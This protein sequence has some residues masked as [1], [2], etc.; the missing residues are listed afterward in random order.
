M[1]LI[2]KIR[3]KAAW[4]IFGAIALAL[5]AFIV[6]DAFMR[7]GSFFGSGST[8]GKVNGESIEHEDFQKKV[9]FYDQ[10]N[11]GQIERNQLTANV[12]DYLV[13]QTI[14]QQQVAKLGLALTP[15][16]RSDVLFGDNPPQWMQQAFTDPKT[17]LFDAATAKKQLQQ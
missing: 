2:Q 5:L 17:G 4:I 1:S 11:G 3:D 9:D 8:I 10:A 14:M 16:E 12:W 15:N 7:R 6:Q 13:N